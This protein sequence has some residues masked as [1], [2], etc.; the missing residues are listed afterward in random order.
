[1]FGV[2]QETEKSTIERHLTQEEPTPLRGMERL[3][4]RRMVREA[5]QAGKQEREIS[6]PRKREP[7]REP[8]IWDALDGIGRE[9]ASQPDQST[10][11][12]AMQRIQERTT[13]QQQ[14]RKAVKAERDRLE[15]ET[16]EREKLEQERDYGMDLG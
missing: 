15:R 8:S 9:Q 4:A 14:E 13:E 16:A 12:E 5:L 11:S 2:V 1:M 6:T 10:K 3:K 7:E